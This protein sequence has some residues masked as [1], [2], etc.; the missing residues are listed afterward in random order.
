MTIFW[1][2]AESLSPGTYRVEIF[3]DGYVIGKKTFKW[4]K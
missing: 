4:S 2:V 1:D 3:A